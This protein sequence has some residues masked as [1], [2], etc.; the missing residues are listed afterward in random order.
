[1]KFL[2]PQ[3][4]PFSI[5]AGILHPGNG[6]GQALDVAGRRVE[7]GEADHIG[8][9]PQAHFDQFQRAG[10]FGDVLGIALG[11]EVDE[12]PAAHAPGHQP[13]DLELVERRANRGPRGTEG[14]GELALRRQFFAVGITAFHDGLAELRGDPGG[15]AYRIGDDRRGSFSKICTNFSHFRAFAKIGLKSA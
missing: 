5:A 13:L 12:G 1:M 4:E 6:I 3:G 14:R 9:D 8:L 2:V 7:H 10:E 15:P 11:P